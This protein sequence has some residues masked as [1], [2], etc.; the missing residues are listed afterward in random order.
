MSGAD[1][2]SSL[3]RLMH[4][5]N[6]SLWGIV[7]AACE[8]GARHALAAIVGRGGPLVLTDGVV[9]EKKKERDFVILFCLCSASGEVGE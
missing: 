7:R 5:F 9:H 4:Y 8:T 1:C 6:L 3:V 2:I